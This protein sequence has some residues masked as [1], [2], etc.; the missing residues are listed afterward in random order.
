MEV[1]SFEHVS[2]CYTDRLDT[3]LS[4]YCVEIFALIRFFLSSKRLLSR[5]WFL[6]DAE[7][8]SD[9]I[10]VT[11][12]MLLTMPSPDDLAIFLRFFFDILVVCIREGLGLVYSQ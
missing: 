1:Q 7:T 12:K 6:E 8:T 9:H 3:P 4:Q 11:I 2:D 10:L 5:R